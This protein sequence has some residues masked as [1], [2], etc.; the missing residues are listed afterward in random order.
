[1]RKLPTQHPADQATVQERRMRAPAA[2]RE[3]GYYL[4][5]VRSTKEC[6]CSDSLRSHRV[7]GRHA[8]ASMA[9]V[10]KIVF[11]GPV[12]E[13]RAVGRACD[14]TIWAASIRDLNSSATPPHVSIGRFEAIDRNGFPQPSDRGTRACSIDRDA[15]A[16]PRPATHARAIGWRHRQTW[17]GSTA[18]ICAAA[19]I[20]VSDC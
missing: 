6:R 14:E 9:T 1:M 18:R 3:L 4:Q 12:A 13:R 7:A 17:P 11:I 15:S 8:S 2:C 20:C 16:R 10:A 19:L 5:I